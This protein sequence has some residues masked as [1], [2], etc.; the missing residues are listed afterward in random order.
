ME[1]M[2]GT[3]L[4]KKNKQKLPTIARG[5]SKVQLVGSSKLQKGDVAMVG[6]EGPEHMKE[7][8]KLYYQYKSNANILAHSPY[9]TN[10]Q[11]QHE[12]VSYIQANRCEPTIDQLSNINERYSLG[13]ELTLRLA[14][15]PLHTIQIRLHC[16]SLVVEVTLQAR[17]VE[18]LEL[19]LKKEYALQEIKAKGAISK[20]EQIG[21]FSSFKPNSQVDFLLSHRSSPL[22]SG[23]LDVNPWFYTPFVG[24]VQ[25]KDFRMIRCLGSGGFSLVYL[26]RDRMRGDF[27]AL[28]LIDKSFIL[29]SER[30]MIVENERFVLG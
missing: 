14:D 25:L 11:H 28:K 1:K 5:S 26:V 8:R 19:L 30:S 24:T 10:R 7:L 18:E 27:H 23:S 2:S 3:L 29:E 12:V 20:V 22:S 17:N 15:L 21:G 6:M 16:F 4:S 9:Y 13:H